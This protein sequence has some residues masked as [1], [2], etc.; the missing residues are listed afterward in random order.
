MKSENISSLGHIKSV[1]YELFGKH[2]L[3]PMSKN[4]DEFLFNNSGKI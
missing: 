3:T 1:I 4:C 2:E